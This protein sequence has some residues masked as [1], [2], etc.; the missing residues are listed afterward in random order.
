MEIEEPILV[1][2]G[3]TTRSGKGTVV[4]NLKKRKDFFPKSIHGDRFFKF[5]IPLD[6]VLSDW[7]NWEIPAAM[8]FERMVEEI[9]NVIIKFKQTRKPEQKY[10]L[11]ESF[12]LYSSPS[13]VELLHKKIYLTISKKTCFLRRNTTTCVPPVYFEQILWPAFRTHNKNILDD[14]SILIIN[15]ENPVDLVTSSVIDYL[16]GKENNL[17]SATEI[18]RN[19]LEDNENIQVLYQ[20]FDQGKIRDLKDILNGNTSVE[21]VLQSNIGRDSNQTLKETSYQSN[22]GIS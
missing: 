19:N 22:C 12:I 15:G 17:L 6:E 16:E 9:K 14:P 4:N 2:I 1:G 5:S 21:T 8:D 3:G 7:S 13:I 20:I 18:H 10:I 11:I